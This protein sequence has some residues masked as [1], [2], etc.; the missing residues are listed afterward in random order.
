MLTRSHA[1][2]WGWLISGVYGARVK[3]DSNYH[4]RLVVCLTVALGAACSAPLG[5]VSARTAEAEDN[6]IE[7]S[8]TIESPDGVG[9]LRTGLVNSAGKS[10]EILCATCHPSNSP[11]ESDFVFHTREVIEHGPLGCDYC[12][13]PGDRSKLRL[14]NGERLSMADTMVLCAQ[15]HGPQ[16]RDYQHGSHGGMQGYWDRRAGPSSKKHCVGCHHPHRP[17]FKGMWPKPGPIDGG[18]EVG[19]P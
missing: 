5:D 13:A 9:A 12:H 3:M 2:G 8:V 11:P 15:C 6:P 4:G 14:A 7:Y 19:H 10:A 17:S 16:F 1:I 18:T